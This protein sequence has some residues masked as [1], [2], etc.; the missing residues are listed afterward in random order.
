MK[1]SKQELRV[2]N[3]VPKWVFLMNISYLVISKEK[4]EPVAPED[5]HE[6][7]HEHNILYTALSCA[8]SLVL[9][10]KMMPGPIL[11]LP[12][13]AAGNEASLRVMSYMGKSYP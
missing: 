13:W 9:G 1:E 6:I 8:W 3:A 4:T 11:F 5:N 7:L 10:A 12:F 2:L